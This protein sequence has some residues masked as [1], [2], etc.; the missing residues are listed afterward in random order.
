MGFLQICTG[1]VLLQ[2]SKSAKDVPDAAVLK[3]DL[4]QMR[5]VAEQEDP[6]S[7][8]KADA[9]RGTAAL[10]RSFSKAR[11]HREVDEAKRVYTER[12]EPIRE[13]EHVEWDGLRRRKTIIEPGQ[14]GIQRRKSIHPPLGLTHFPNEDQSV[15]LAE[16]HTAFPTSQHNQGQRHGSASSASTMPHIFGLPA[17]LRPT[18]VPVPRGLSEFAHADTEYKSPANATT[19]VHFTPS[20]FEHSQRDGA[21]TGLSHRTN[22][23]ADDYND[24]TPL[25]PPHASFAQEDLTARRQFSFSNVFGRGRRGSEGEERRVSGTSSAVSRFGLKGRGGGGSH[26]HTVT[27]E[28]RLGLVK[29]DSNMPGHH[30]GSTG[31]TM[32]GREVGEGEEYESPVEEDE[33]EERLDVRR[34]RVRG[35]AD[36]AR[37]DDESDEF[38][39]R[40]DDFGFEKIGQGRYDRGGTGGQAF[41]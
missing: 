13:N 12:M 33:E 1:V 23:V 6:E 24:G 10:I 27:E 16:M 18:V 20:T 29:G 21:G 22:E 15:P 7:E 38:D 2:L 4:D 19:T 9:I 8:P 31:Q 41:V 34:S 17:S 40:H 30:G 11:R 39:D 36:V 26:Q 35:Y 14:S 5:T 3:G 37:E 25:P 28:E 32:L